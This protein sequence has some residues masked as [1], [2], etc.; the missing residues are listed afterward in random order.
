M[1]QVYE[2][3]NCFLRRDISIRRLRTV[4]IFIQIDPKQL[5][6]ALFG[7][8]SEEY[9]FCN[10]SCTYVSKSQYFF[11]NLNSNFSN[12]LDLRNF[13][14]FVAKNCSDLS[15]FEQTVL[16][17]SKFL[18]IFGLKPRI[19]KVFLDH[20]NNFFSQQV[21]KILLTKYHFYLS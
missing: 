11:F 2:D 16:M 9:T 1:G 13:Q 12:L 19:S 7:Q 20:Q 6:I 17:I 21:S 8:P 5:L 10:F 15:L 4:E 14:H 18:Q 3:K